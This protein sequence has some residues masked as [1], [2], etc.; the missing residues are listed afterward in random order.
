MCTHSP[1]HWCMPQCMCR[2]ERTTCA[3]QLPPSTM[4][5]PGSNWSRQ[6]WRQVPFPAKPLHLP[7]SVLPYNWT[8]TKEHQ[9]YE[10]LLYRALTACSCVSSS[11]CLHWGH[12]SELCLQE[13]P[14]S[15]SKKQAHLL[16][17]HCKG[18]EASQFI[19]AGQQRKLIAEWDE[20]IW[21]TPYHPTE[22]RARIDQ[23]VDVYPIW[24]L[25][26]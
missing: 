1:V 19:T 25:K 7:S 5:P 11:A 22:V 10:T 24:W 13:Q 16:T 4:W 3:R 9:Y 6:A 2:G 20:A 26:Q 12:F 14:R 18:R 23:Y 8:E 21:T 17:A 15:W